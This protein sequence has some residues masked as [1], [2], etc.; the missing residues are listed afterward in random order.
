MNRF[1]IVNKAE[2]MKNPQ[3]YKHCKT[4]TNTT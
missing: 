1:D 4:N 3:P 2:A